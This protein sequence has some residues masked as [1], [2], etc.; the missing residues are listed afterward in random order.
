MAPS[1]APIGT[2]VLGRRSLI[3]SGLVGGGLMLGGG[4]WPR[5]GSAA[6]VP[7]AL[8]MPFSVRR[9][10]A[11]IGEHVLTFTRMGERIE[12]LIEAAFEIKVA[13]FTAWRY[14]HENREVWENGRLISLDSRTDDDGNRLSVTARATAAGL[15]VDGRDGRFVAPSD[16]L[17]TSWWNVGVVGR[18]QALD[19]QNGVLRSYAVSPG[20]WEQVTAGG[21][22]IR[23]RRHTLSGDINLQIW[24]SDLDQWVKM[25]FDGRG[26]S[27]DYRLR[28]DGAVLVDAL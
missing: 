13:F 1:S 16:T 15:E 5:R 18:N 10:D 25:H 26:E 19:T 22:R 20:A 17:S 4:M 7:P 24:Y 8:R 23:A 9:G 3:T 28:D 6:G 21:R 2:A 14:S 27:V 12:V 11:F